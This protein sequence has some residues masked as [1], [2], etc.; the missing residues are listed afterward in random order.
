MEL[1]D[2]YK[3]ALYVSQ[4]LK[5]I[6]KE[7]ISS[8]QIY[9]VVHEKNHYEFKLKFVAYNYFVVIF[10]Y[11]LDIIG[12]SIVCGDGSAISLM[13]GKHCFSDEN[14]NECFE[15]IRKNIELRIPDKYLLAY[16]W[17]N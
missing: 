1:N 2:T 14:L 6:F 16:G 7:K 5:S 4:I 10:Q 15:E 8:S 17:L 13:N 9:D 11:E 12:C 3:K